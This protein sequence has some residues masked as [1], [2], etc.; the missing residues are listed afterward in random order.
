MVSLCFVYNFCLLTPFLLNIHNINIP[1]IENHNLKSDLYI[2]LNLV[3][4]FNFKYFNCILSWLPRIYSIH[5][6]FFFLLLNVFLRQW[7]THTWLVKNYP[8]RWD[9]PWTHRDQDASVLYILGLKYWANNP[10]CFKILATWLRK[11]WR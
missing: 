10:G 6:V 4:L 5:W 3:V 11:C 2:F 8:W 7:P 1:F 9:W